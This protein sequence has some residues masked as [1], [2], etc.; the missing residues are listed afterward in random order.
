MASKINTDPAEEV[1]VDPMSALTKMLSKWYDRPDQQ[2]RVHSHEQRVKWETDMIL[3]QILGLE[4]Y[5]IEATTEMRIAISKDGLSRTEAVQ[6]LQAMNEPQRG[7]NT[8][9]QF[10]SDAIDDQKRPKV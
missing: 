5:E 4:I 1:F 6:A 9:L 2:T 10:V 3:A 7:L 8:G